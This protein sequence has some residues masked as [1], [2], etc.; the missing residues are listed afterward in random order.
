MKITILLSFV[1]FFGIV[2]HSQTSQVE[3]TVK[4]KLTDETIIGAHVIIGTE[5]KAVTDFNGK[6]TLKV[7]YGKYPIKI[8]FVGYAEYTDTI[9]VKSGFTPV[10][11]AMGTQEI[12]EVEVTAD[13]GEVNRTPVSITKIDQ[14]KL[15][16]ELGARDLPMV[17]NSTPGIY[18]TN[19]GGGDGDAR[20][21]M[22]GFSQR[23]I[24]VMVDGVPVNDMENGWVYWSNW[25]GLGS[26]T[27][28][29]QVQRGLGASKIVSPSVG[30]TI[31]IVTQ[32][33]ENK[34]GVRIK[35]EAGSG[36]FNQVSLGYNSGKLKGDWG[37]T[38]AGSFRYRDGW[39]DK[40]NS[41]GGFYYAKVQK[42][43]GSH[44]I[45]ISAFGA[46]QEHGQRSFKAPIATWNHDKALRYGAD[47][48]GWVERGYRYNEHWG[49]LNKRK[50]GELINERRNYYHK[51]QITFRHF[52]KLKEKL[53]MSNVVYASIGKGGGT[54]MYDY[55]G[56]Y[57]TADGQI[58]FDRIW[59]ANQF[60]EIAGT[61]Y[62]NIDPIYD[63]T[64]LKASNVL[65]SA[66]NNHWWVGYL[67]N[68]KYQ[69]NDKWTFT[70]GIDYRYYEGE[71]YHEINDL[72][73]GDYF[74]NSANLNDPDPKQRE[75]DKIA[76][77]PY[78]R[79]RDAL[80][81]WAGVYALVEYKGTRW[82]VFLN[83]SFSA[84]GYK[85]IDYF[86]RKM[87]QVG[88]TTLRI[89]YADTILYNG[90][91]Y[92]ASSAGLEF[93]HTKWKW[94]PAYTFKAG[95]N[96][97][98]T[99][100]MGIYMN[101]GYLSRAPMFTNVV[102]YE[103]TELRFYEETQNEEIF[104]GELGLTMN[105]PKL[106]IAV[107]GYATYWNNKPHP[108]GVRLEIAPGEFEKYNVFG[109][110][111]LHVGGE[112]N[113][114]YK[115]IKQLSLE[116]MASFGDWRWASPGTLRNSTDTIRF[117]PT[118][119]HVSDAAQS[120]YALSIRSDF[121]KGAYIKIRYTIFDRHWANMDPFGLTGE[122]ARRDSWKMP[123][124]GVMDINVGYT[125][126]FKKLALVIRGNIF[127]VLNSSFIQDGQ[128]NGY[129]TGYEDFDAKSATVFF[130]QGITWNVSLGL[131][132]F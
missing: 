56:A 73:G 102:D 52:G 4:D 39:V 6:F 95:A 17:L 43:F 116:G 87:L 103:A 49:I 45:A 111:A 38:L 32:G 82:S 69:I 50:D 42:K 46:P 67:G 101:A 99:E 94:I 30:G 107:N 119:V 29:M 126:K 51:P 1:L 115:I 34:F 21:T 63:S 12:Q 132:I 75:G 25:F 3:G 130:G 129:G 57:R 83:A 97:R 27:Q 117:D 64:A 122:N 41:L 65:T 80:V 71:H 106:A 19:Q 22:R 16:E 91:V 81:Q 124:Y 44:M 55:G 48:T 37:I 62:P 79:H 76:W 109:M 90:Q 125:H 10:N 128:N 123:T 113:I 14:K 31:N 47:T 58:D 33:M 120:V 13:L 24:A 66:V 26:I 72:L 53:Y 121:V 18:A 114:T 118:G 104:A 20:I 68:I 98:L 5:Y 96:Y 93:D 108:F 70:T 36:L 40:A 85:G 15:N 7:P 28:S 100:N 105:L 59:D 8:T 78:H 131:N 112:A 84:N 88:D 61:I 127:N 54:K 74:V 110:S 77:Q 11:V 23:N 2:S 92:N 35:Y 9:E 89:G 60:T 86:N